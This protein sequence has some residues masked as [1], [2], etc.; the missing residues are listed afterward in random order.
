MNLAIVVAM[1]A[2]LAAFAAVSALL[3]HW[4][5]GPVSR[6]AGQL[7]APTRF[8]LTDFLWLMIELQVLLAGGVG[9]VGDGL[10]PRAL[11]V[12]MTILSLPIIVLWG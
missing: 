10:P 5:L 2:G 1:L 4:L 7:N 11:L 3:G 6:A 8:Q 9:L 12:L